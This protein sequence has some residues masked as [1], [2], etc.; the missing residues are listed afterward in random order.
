MVEE[1]TALAEGP[2]LMEPLPNQ[3]DAQSSEI[4]A[5]QK[6]HL[7][8]LPWDGREAYHGRS[9]MSMFILPHLSF[10]P[11]LIWSLS[12]RY[13]SDLTLE[14]AQASVD[15]LVQHLQ[16]ALSKAKEDVARLQHQ[17]LQLQT[18]ATKLFDSNAS[19]SELLYDLSEW[20]S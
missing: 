5:V 15:S 12:A 10:P 9:R 13:L 7:F 20:C 2:I 14:R 11:R 4:E 8:Y 19:Q 1:P 18:Q 17:A 3:R 6:V 16:D